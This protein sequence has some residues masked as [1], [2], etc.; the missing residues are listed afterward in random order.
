MSQII[1]KES[2][3]KNIFKKLFRNKLATIAFALITIEIILIIGAPLFTSYDPTIQNLKEI[4]LA[5][6]FSPKLIIDSK[7]NEFYSSIHLLGTDNLGRDMWSRIL[8]GGRISLSVGFIAILFGMTIGVAAG[9][10]AAYYPKIDSVVMR[11]MDIMFSFPGI[12]LAMLIVAMMGTSLVNVTLAISIWSIPM[13]ARIVRGEAL[14]IKQNDYIKAIK[15]LGASDLR[16][17]FI[18]IL[19]NC[20]ASI[21]VYATMRMAT[22]ILSI[23]S[24]SYLGIGAQPPLSEWGTMVAAGREFIYDSPHMI[25]VPGVAIII[26][27]LCFNILGDVLRDILDPNLSDNL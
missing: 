13:F 17:I 3:I 25:I 1:E 6:G 15:S 23:A 27:M 9:L 2:Y 19:P 5:P 14:K 20:L 11:I 12:L 22:A 10:F 21:V 24:L 18:H 7:G 4:L 8:Y 26:T 16:I